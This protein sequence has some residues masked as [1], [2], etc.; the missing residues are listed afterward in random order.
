M[1]KTFLSIGSGPGIG[2]ETARLFAAAGYDIVLSSRSME[3][4][5]PLAEDLA[6]SGARV[7]LQQVD[8][9]KVQ[10][11]FD[12]VE[13]VA[14]EGEL[15]LHYNTG[16]LHYDED[17]NLIMQPLGSQS[18]NDMMYDLQVNTASALAAV[19][20]A[21]PGMKRQGKGTILLTG[22]GV[23]VNPIADMLTLSVG[24]AGLRHLVLTMFERLS[25]DNIHI[26]TVTVDQIVHPGTK[27]ARDIADAFLQLH[28]Q[29]K[30]AWTW[31]TWFGN[32][33]AAATA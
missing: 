9:S 18:L 29:P 16:S 7:T 2:L 30:S 32:W 13:Q 17:G 12:L 33:D 27:D 4:L 1:S 22:G 20:A 28:L 10:Q 26:A 23:A 11:V 31:E 15:V 3:R 6:S 14:G 21:V 8:T 19:K 24:K 5:E 25:L